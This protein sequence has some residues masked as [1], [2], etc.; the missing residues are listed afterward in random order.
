MDAVTSAAATSAV[1]ATNAVATLGPKPKRPLSAFNLFY[2]FKRKKVLDAISAGRNEKEDIAALVGASPGLEDRPEAASIVRGEDG[3]ATSPPRELNDLRRADIRSQL[4]GNLLPRDTRDRQHRTNQSAMNGTMSFLE[5][6]R[7]MNASWKT[8]D[9]FAKGVFDELAEEG[10]EVYR[11][12]IMEYNARAQAL[13]VPSEKEKAH[14][15]KV[16]KK[17]KLPAKNNAPENTPPPQARDDVSVGGVKNEVTARVVHHGHGHHNMPRHYHGEQPNNGLLDLLSR[18][19]NGPVG[20]GDRGAMLARISGHDNSLRTVSADYGQEGHPSHYHQHHQ[21]HHRGNHCISNEGGNG[22]AGLQARVRE[23]EGQLAAE[24][25]RARVRELEG[26]LARQKSVEEGLRTQ[27]GML[28]RNVAPPPQQQQ[29]HALHQAMIPQGGH[30][31]PGGQHHHIR[32]GGVGG[33]A[34]PPSSSL[35][36][37][38]T[39]AQGDGLWSLV[40]ASMIHPSVRAQE[41][42]S[43]PQRMVSTRN[44]VPTQLQPSVP[45]AR[46]VSE[47]EAASTTVR[48]REPSPG[49][50]NLSSNKKQKCSVDF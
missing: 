48:E 39:Q 15:A 37:S 32:H 18:E 50:D 36:N 12:R 7:H 11:A 41:R 13:G 33:G 19:R 28:A 3:K 38:S 31:G 26:D 16:S 6:G 1:T 40:S 27:L 47:V 49:D 5:L 46:S 4:E 29:Q 8:C 9:H 25:L 14:G 30:R 2:R 21:P 24:R 35:V 42:T 22:E 17:K 10:R 23:L 43:M 45:P 44:E 34:P 20:A